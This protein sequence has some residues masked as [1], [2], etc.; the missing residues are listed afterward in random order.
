M[1]ALLGRAQSLH[2]D[3]NERCLF[4]GGDE[5]AD[6]RLSD[7]GLQLE[8]HIRLGE[9]IDGYLSSYT[10]NEFLR[11]HVRYLYGCERLRWSSTR[12]ACRDVGYTVTGSAIM[13]APLM[14][15]SGEPG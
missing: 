15:G 10:G 11:H 5:D 12:T 4:S 13:P 6:Q 9:Y 8:Q 3:G 7:A 2:D 1:A 14:A